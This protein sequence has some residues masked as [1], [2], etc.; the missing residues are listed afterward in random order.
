MAMVDIAY[1]RDG[2]TGQVLF[3]VAGNPRIVPNANANTY[4]QMQARIQNEVLGLITADDVK[5]A[6]QDAIAEYE[7]EDFYF[8]NMRTFGAATGSNSDLQT[9]QGKEFYSYQDLS[10]LINMPHISKISI[11]AFSN[12][13][14][15]VNRTQQWM[16][17]VSMSPTWNGLPTDWAWISGSIRLYPIPNDSY[18]LIIDGTIRFP[19]LVNDADYNVW[20]NRAEALIRT[21]SKRLL[22]TNITRDEDQA[23]IMLREIHGDPAFPMRQGFLAQ[24]R[25]ET[26]R[27]AGGAGKIRPSRGYL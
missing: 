8:N 18:P 11:L 7:R 4:G 13:Y 6:I 9:V 20:S 1:A 22:F 10:V 21:E 14:P 26:S 27:R 19:P 17:D 12:R 5:N 15:L 23:A 2:S 25:R 24:L 16:D 3:D